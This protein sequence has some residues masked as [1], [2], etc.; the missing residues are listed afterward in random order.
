MPRRLKGALVGVVISALVTAGI[1]EGAIRILH[2][3]PDDVPIT[4]HAAAGDEDY[5]PDSNA[6]V[7]SIL[8]I[9]HRTNANGLR[10]AD[11]PVPRTGGAARVV[12]VGDSVVWGFGIPEQETIPASLERLAADSGL[13]LEA[14]NF[15]VV[16]YNT[17]NEKGK[18]AR[19]APIVR[20]DVTVV[21]VLF[22]D[23]QPRAEHFRITS[24]GTLADPR[25]RAP[26][27]DE[28][29]PI[30]EKSALFHAAIQLYWWAVPPGDEGKAFDLANLPGVLAQLDEIRGIASAVGSSLIVAA[31]PSAVPEAGRFA[32]LSDALRRFCEERNVSFVDLS[33]TLGRPARREHLLPADA[34]HPT[35]QGARLVAEALLPRVADALKR[36]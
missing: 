14:W 2:L 20:P 4:Y 27:P 28:W 34:V 29:R 25:R 33:A 24:V 35:A 10:G 8:G 18:Y 31:M 30:L 36:R 21:V 26:Y 3:I 23:L 1:L 19:L 16:A 22:N 12:V 11:R 15:G 5:A 6:A 17:Y 7:R 13:A 32:V 9:A